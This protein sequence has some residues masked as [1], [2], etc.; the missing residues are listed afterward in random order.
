M[1]H[2]NKIKEKNCN[3]ICINSSDLHDVHN[4]NFI[5]SHSYFPI[6]N[7]PNYPNLNDDTIIT[8]D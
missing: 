5:P 6:E 8:N 1:S 2:N 3:K 7:D 4:K